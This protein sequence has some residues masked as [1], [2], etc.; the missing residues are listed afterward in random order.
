MSAGTK[1]GI[2]MKSKIEQETIHDMRETIKSSIITIS[3]VF[4]S[5][6]AVSSIFA[7][8]STIDRDIVLGFTGGEIGALIIY[9]PAYLVYTLLER[10]CESWLI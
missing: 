4:L 5:I 1:E 6:I 2:I 8:V 7:P 10:R 3:V 9:V